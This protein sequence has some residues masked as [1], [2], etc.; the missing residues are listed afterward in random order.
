MINPYQKVKS[1]CVCKNYTNEGIGMDSNIYNL[2]KTELSV[3]ASFT[4]IY[5][6]YLVFLNAYKPCPAELFSFHW[7]FC[8]DHKYSP[9]VQL[10]DQLFV[11]VLITLCCFQHL[12]LRPQF[13]FQGRGDEFSVE[14]LLLLPPQ[15]GED[16]PPP[17]GHGRVPLPLLPPEGR[18][19]RRLRCRGFGGCPLRTA[20]RQLLSDVCRHEPEL[21]RWQKEHGAPQLPGVGHLRRGRAVKH[22]EWVGRILR[23]RSS[24]PGRQRALHPGICLRWFLAICVQLM[25]KKYRSRSRSRL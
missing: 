7:C 2:L 10:S 22:D 6:H 8:E 16:L 24:S 9:S 5:I 19:R 12:F 15:Q 18:P 11:P 20:R 14:P 17:V 25:R 21:Q 13:R 3:I 1:V 23:L 4:C